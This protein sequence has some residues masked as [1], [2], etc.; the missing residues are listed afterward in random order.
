VVN[1]AK[2]KI[3]SQVFIFTKCKIYDNQSS[4]DHRFVHPFGGSLQFFAEAHRLNRR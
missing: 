1:I 2:F 4:P 3:S